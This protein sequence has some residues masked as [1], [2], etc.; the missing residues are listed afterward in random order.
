MSRPDLLQVLVAPM[1]LFPTSLCG[2]F[3]CFVHAAPWLHVFNLNLLGC[4]FAPGRA[5]TLATGHAQGR[6]PVPGLRIS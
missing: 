6:D 3:R 1:C 4:P 2:H 5:S